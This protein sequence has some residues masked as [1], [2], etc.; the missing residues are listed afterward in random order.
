VDQE[1]QSDSLGSEPT[2]FLLQTHI[3]EFSERQVMITVTDKLDHFVTRGS[4]DLARKVLDL[5]F[6]FWSKKLQ[7]T[8]CLSK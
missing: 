8:S 3:K 1:G 6:K 4:A 5:H 7:V 2:R